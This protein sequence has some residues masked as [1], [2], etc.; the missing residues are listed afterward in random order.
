MNDKIS[1]WNRERLTAFYEKYNPEKVKEVDEVLSKY[2]GKENQLFNALVRKYG[3]EPGDSMDE[4]DGSDQEDIMSPIKEEESALEDVKE[5]ED[6]FQLRRVV[7]CP[8]DSLPAEYCEYGPCFDECKAWLVAEVPTLYL[9][10]YG[11]TVQDL[12]EAERQ[13]ANGVEDISLEINGTSKIAKSRKKVTRKSDQAKS[14]IT[15]STSSRKGRKHVTIICGLEDYVEEPMTIKDA[16]KK[17]GKRFACSASIIK[18]DVGAQQVQ[19]QGECQVELMQVLP[20]MFDVDERTI[21]VSD[22]KKK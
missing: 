3:P 5:T 11:R 12:M 19:L 17:L 18:N 4:S 13:I 7:Y 2:K 8:V 15:I 22:R 16:A 10:K 14:P 20:E 21:I 1:S 9:Q 6:P